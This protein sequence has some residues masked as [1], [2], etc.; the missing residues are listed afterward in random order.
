MSSIVV[1]THD[2]IQFPYVR[3]SGSGSAFRGHEHLEPRKEQATHTACNLAL[4][5]RNCCSLHNDLAGHASALVRLA[6]VAV[7][8][9]GVK[10]GGHS[11]SGGVQVVLVAKLVSAGARLHD[12]E[13][14]SELHRRRLQRPE[15]ALLM[16]NISCT[17]KN[18]TMTERPALAVK[19]A[20][21]QCTIMGTD[22]QDYR[23]G[24]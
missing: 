24:P 16:W 17:E 15:Q 22:T 21:K 19:E 9:G 2:H 14:A 7:L 10:L 8:S 11:L 18:R 23:A 1:Y 4:P 3:P 13:S 20:G 12:G 6:V 5:H